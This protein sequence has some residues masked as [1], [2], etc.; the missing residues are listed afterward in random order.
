MP[1]ETSGPVPYD[2]VV[3]AAIERVRALL[4]SSPPYPGV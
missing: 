1:V 4:P 3:H 2:K